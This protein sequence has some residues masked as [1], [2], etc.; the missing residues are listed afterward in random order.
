MREHA[1]DRVSLASLYY[2]LHMVFMKS[3]QIGI[4]SYQEE[5]M[6]RGKAWPGQY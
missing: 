2:D 4:I 3:V 1:E 5:K 6:E